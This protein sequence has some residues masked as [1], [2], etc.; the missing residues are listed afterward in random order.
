MTSDS[1]DFVETVY[2]GQIRRFACVVGVGRGRWRLRGGH[3]CN[4]FFDARVEMFDL[5]AESVDLGQQHFRELTVMLVE[6]SGQCLDQGDAF[7]P[8]GLST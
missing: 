7:D 8:L 3:V 4:Q 1:G 2:C 5:C 6:T